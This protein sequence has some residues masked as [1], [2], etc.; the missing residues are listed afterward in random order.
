MEQPKVTDPYWA[1]EVVTTGVPVSVEMVT[2]GWARVTLPA[3][4]E[5]RNG[6][7]ELPKIVELVMPTEALPGEW[8][9]L[10]HQ[11]ESSNVIR[12]PKTAGN[13]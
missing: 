3:P 11:Q 7:C 13:H 5:T 1:P 8:V 4:P 9:L 12:F 2:E 6:R 10:L